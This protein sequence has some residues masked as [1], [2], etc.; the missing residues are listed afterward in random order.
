[1]KTALKIKVATVISYVVLSTMLVVQAD[2]ASAPGWHLSLAA[3]AQ[4]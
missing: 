4:H 3:A 2:Q 1:M